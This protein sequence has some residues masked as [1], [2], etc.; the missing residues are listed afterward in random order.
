MKQENINE[1]VESYWTSIPFNELFPLF[2][3]K[4]LTKVST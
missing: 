4:C 3:K 2:Q 1:S